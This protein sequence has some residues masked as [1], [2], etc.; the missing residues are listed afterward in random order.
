MKKLIL[1]LLVLFGLQSRA[2]VDWCDSLY[3]TTIP[4][5]VFSVVGMYTN[6]VNTIADTVSWAWTVCNSSLC[7]S[8]PGTYASFPLI[9]M[10]DTIKVCYNAYIA[11]IPLIS[12]TERCDSLVFNGTEWVT[13]PINTVG[14][15]E[16]PLRPVDSKSYD[17][18]GRE[19][20][21]IPNGVMYIKNQKLHMKK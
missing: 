5:P 9:Q 14:V 21:Y 16:V 4:S 1:I 15:T 3:Y 17:L 7:F 13:F 19:L 18:M 2:Q 10:S 6:G 8:E 12:C 11:T 20:Y